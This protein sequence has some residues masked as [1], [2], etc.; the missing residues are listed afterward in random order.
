MATITASLFTA[1]DG[2]VDPGVGT[3]HVVANVPRMSRRSVRA[4]DDE[5]LDY[6]SIHRSRSPLGVRSGRSDLAAMGAPREEGGYP[7]CW[8]HQFENDNTETAR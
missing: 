5:G 2:V 7:A 8:A 4:A 3:T 6:L 1:L